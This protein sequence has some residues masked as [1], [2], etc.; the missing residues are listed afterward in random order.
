MLVSPNGLP[1]RDIAGLFV[2]F[3]A[4]IVQTEYKFLGTIILTYLFI[5][6]VTYSWNV[7][8]LERHTAAAGD[9]QD[10]VVYTV[11]YTIEAKDDTYSSSAYG[12]VGLDAPEEGYEVVPFADL[13]PEL[14][15]TWTKEKLGGDEKVAEIEAALKAQIDNQHAPVS[16]AGFPA[17]WS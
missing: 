10:G 12:S 3:T 7:A 15:L 17:G 13:T 6:S 11:H 1:P 8:Q 16:A 14:V 4:L 2:R 9:D 5:M